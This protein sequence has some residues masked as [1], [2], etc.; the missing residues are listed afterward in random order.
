MTDLKKIMLIDDDP[1]DQIFFRD[2]IQTILPNL[3]CELTSTCQEALRLLENPPSPDFIFMDL[4]MPV[5]NGFDCLVIPEKSK[6]INGY[7]RSY[8]YNFKKSQ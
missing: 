3:K 6:K 5:M 7:S 2:A 1:D 8:F 4:N